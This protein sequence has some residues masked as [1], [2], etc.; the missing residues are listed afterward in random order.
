MKIENNIANIRVKLLTDIRTY[1]YDS[2]VLLL[3]SDRETEKERDK[4]RDQKK[5]EREGKRK[6]YINS[7]N[8]RFASAK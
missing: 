7:G 4:K 6:R 8:P 5:R 2:L 1:S 3:Q